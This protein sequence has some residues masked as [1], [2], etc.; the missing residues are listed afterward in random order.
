[1]SINTNI[2]PN[3]FFIRRKKPI[4]IDSTD[5]IFI[6][7]LGN[8]CTNLEIVFNNQNMMCI[9]QNLNEMKYWKIEP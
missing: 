3:N 7:K 6:Q 4:Y 2:I 1:M 9:N 8:D 5:K